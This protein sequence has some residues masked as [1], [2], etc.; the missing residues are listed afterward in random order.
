M[1]II[2]HPDPMRETVRAWR[3]EGRRIGFVPTMGALHE[4]HLSLVRLA[5]AQAECTVVS[6]FVNPTQ[7]GE[8]EDYDS[9]PRDF[10]HDEALCR[11]EGVDALFHPAAADMYPP[12][13]AVFIDEPP[14]AKIL[15][16]ALR[17]GHFRGVLTVVA[18]L[19]NLVEPDVAVFGQKDA[20]QLFLIRKM[21]EDLN[22]PARIL[23]GPIVREQDGLAMSSRNAYLSRT[24]RTDA[25]CLRRALDRAQAL[26]RGGERDA[27]VIRRAM[28]ERI[29]E[30][31]SAR[32]EY[33]ELVDPR[34][35]APVTEAGSA[36][37]ALV[38]ARV[39][40]TRL[41]DNAFLDPTP[42]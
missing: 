37:L 41:L 21:V 32:A 11:E 27:H 8:G 20:Q 6:V 7:F 31:A 1:H 33:A 19:L 3:R 16:G 38:A 24:E 34:T 5:R 14:A 17:P 42:A 13:H 2:E 23:S 12:G 15:E 35:F 29:H 22:L 39:G 25:V 9:Y 40:T 4:A 26:F 18:K 28:R 10:S 30:A 36:S